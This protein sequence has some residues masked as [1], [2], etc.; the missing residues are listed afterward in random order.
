MHTG[1]AHLGSHTWP[2]AVVVQKM[3]ST[4]QRDLRD[5]EGFRKA[6]PQMSPAH[7]CVILMLWG[8]AALDNCKDLTHRFFI[9]DLEVLDYNGRSP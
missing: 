3:V 9:K 7:I 2:W 6:C 5:L 1:G 4:N 8:C